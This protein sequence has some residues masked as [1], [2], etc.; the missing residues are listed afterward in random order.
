V[1]AAVMIIDDITDE[2]NF[3]AT[4]FTIYVLAEP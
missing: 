4:S 3:V 2:Y 1:V